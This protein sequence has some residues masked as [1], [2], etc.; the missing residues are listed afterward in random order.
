M[1]LPHGAVG[2]SAVYD[3]GIPDHNH[4]LFLVSHQKD[5]KIRKSNPL[6]GLV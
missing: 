1:A 4:L 2:L 3:C 5:S 6:Q